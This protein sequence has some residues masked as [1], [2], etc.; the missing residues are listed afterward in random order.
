MQYKQYTDVHEFYNLTA[1]FLLTH[2]AQNLVLL[3]NLIIGVEGKD[4]SGWRDPS[5]W[6]MAAVND[7]NGLQLVAVMTPPYNITL[8]AKDNT[9]NVAASDVVLPSPLDIKHWY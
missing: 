4:K 2:E 6:T 7:E 1:P 9:V 5:R 8:F 3:G